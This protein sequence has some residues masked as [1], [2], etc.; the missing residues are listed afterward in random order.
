MAGILMKQ[1]VKDMGVNKSLAGIKSRLRDLTPAMKVC[2]EIWRNSVIKNFMVGGRPAWPKSKK[3]TGLT[4]IASKRLMNSITYKTT[5]RSVS[6]GTNVAYG[7][8]QHEGG[9][10][11]RGAH[12]RLYIQNRFARGPKKGKYKRGTTKGRGETVKSYT[13]TIPP[14]KFLPPQPE[15]LKQME[16]AVSDY[17]L[18]RNAGA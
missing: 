13:I 11:N 16:G 15:D 14:R 10:I 5:P 3:K 12:S 4:L 7:R 18:Q 9:V 2:G 6:Q 17:L 8:I 1:S